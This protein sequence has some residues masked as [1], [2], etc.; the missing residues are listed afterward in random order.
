MRV[1]L[2]RLGDAEHELV[3]STTTCSWTGGLSLILRDVFAIYAACA[4]GE[5]PAL[6]ARGPPPRLRGLAGA[7]GPCARPSA[8][9]GGRWTASTLRPRCRDRGPR[10]A[11]RRGQGAAS[12]CC[13]PER[14]A[15][16]R[17]LARRRGVTVSTLLQGAWG[18]LLASYSGEDDVVFGATVSGRPAELAGMEEMV[19]LF[20]NTLPV[21]VRLGPEARL[22][23]WLGGCRPAQA[24]A[25]RYDFAPLP[26]VQ[27]WSEVPAGQPLFES[28]V[29]F[30]NHPVG[31]GGRGRTASG[32][33]GCGPPPGASRPLPADAPACSPRSGEPALLL[34]PR[35]GG[36]GGGG[37]AWRSTWRRCWRRMA[38]DPGRRLSEL[39]P[40]RDAERAAAAGGVAGPPRS[41]PAEPASTTW[42]R[43]QAQRTPDATALVF[44]G[45]SLTYG[46]LE[47]AADRLAH[48]CA[49]GASARRCA[50]ASARSPRRRWSSPLL[51]VLKAGGAYLPL[52][53][54]SPAERLAYLLDDSG[55][56]PSW[57]QARPRAAPRRAPWRVCV[58][59][60][61]RAG[62]GRE[63]PRRVGW[64]RDNPAYVIYTSGSTGRPKGVVVPHAQRRGLFAA[65]QPWFGFGA[66]RRVRRSSS[67]ALRLL[68]LGVLGALLHGGRWWWCPAR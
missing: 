32:R 66:E 10:R 20:I 9:G 18:L 50:V 68:G 5:T 67:S 44:G 59:E 62:G 53:P 31:R 3:W 28:I 56:R 19:G 24:E 43:A 25:R 34:R 1:A 45:E 49:R 30:E 60:A 7:A 40:L 11:S 52:D 38:G 37:A 23:E 57:S 61:E 35:A 41:V 55:C 21:R 42:S 47:R 22:G 17:L 14:T 63:V 27:K 29:V 36:G 33:A 16:L 48:P 54:A 13:P 15:A 8:S 26:E 12:G 65:T 51:A 64:A 58:A 39:S 46:E 2:F 6:P 4:R